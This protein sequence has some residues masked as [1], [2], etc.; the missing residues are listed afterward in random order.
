MSLVNEDNTLH[1]LIQQQEE[2]SHLFLANTNQNSHGQAILG[3]QRP[4]SNKSF[5][6]KYQNL[7]QQKNMAFLTPL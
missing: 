4:I 2:I 1:F 6:M 7:N 3:M 5:S